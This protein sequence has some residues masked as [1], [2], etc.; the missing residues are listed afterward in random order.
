MSVES[1]SLALRVSGVTA[2]EKLVLIGIA[3]HDG[4][5]GAWP[6]VA[7]LAVYADCSER[8]VQRAL[9][10]LSDRGLITIDHNGG[11]TSRTRADRRPNRY[12]LNLDGVTP[13]T[14]RSDDGV[15]SV[16]ERGDTAMSPEPSLNHPDTSSLRSE[17]NQKE[18]S[19]KGK[20]TSDEAD[21][22]AKEFW[23]WHQTEH[24]TNPVTPYLGLRSVAKS[25][26]NVGFGTDEIID[27]MKRTKVM[28][29][30][31]VSDEA[32]AAR[33][34][35]AGEV[36]P[37]IPQPVFRAIIAAEKWIIERQGNVAHAREAV[38]YF[39]GR[40]GFGVGEAMLRF[41]VAVREGHPDK[42][43]LIAAMWKANIDRFA[44]ELSDYP[45]SMERAFRN[46]Y[47]RAS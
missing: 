38:S 10:S 1:I 8:T 14:P 5:G 42:E 30:K 21:A 25:L 16:D 34:R 45:D 27:A 13:M 20:K 2:T 36:G 6:S 47:W 26:L 11:G 12:V 15:T 4:D 44:G 46:R 43:T 18:V 35:A 41:A 9:S 22:V 31:A 28:T 17:V 3:N 23:E 37:A 40:H 32:L 33:K 19:Q 29:A 7:T 39:V 24:G